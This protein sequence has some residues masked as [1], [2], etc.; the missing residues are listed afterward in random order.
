MGWVLFFAFVIVFV[1][2]IILFNSNKQ[3]DVSTKIQNDNGNINYKSFET[4]KKTRK[5]NI[6]KGKF[7]VSG[8]NHIP[9]DVYKYVQSNVKEGDFFNLIA[10]PQ[11]EH[12]QF[13]IKVFFNDNQIGWVERYYHRKSTLFKALMSNKKINVVC[14]KLDRRG[15]E[16]YGMYIRHIHAKYEYEL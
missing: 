14:A 13:A 4:D 7:E 15:N 8:L 11:N 5:S 10:D 2:F 1:V 6:M 9:K 12:D 16:E 3:V